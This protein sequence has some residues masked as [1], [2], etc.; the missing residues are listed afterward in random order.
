MQHMHPQ[1]NT[2]DQQEHA[3]PATLPSDE[4]QREHSQ[5][6]QHKQRAQQTNSQGPHVHWHIGCAAA[7]TA[8]T[9]SGDRERAG[10]G[11]LARH[12]SPRQCSL[13]TEQRPIKISRRRTSHS[14][15]GRCPASS[16]RCSRRQ[17]PPSPPRPPARDDVPANLG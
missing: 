15:E 16:R 12:A 4:Q 2:D 17:S 3:G 10:N 5:T 11:G 13:T 1:Q 9:W 8:G 14:C 7:A 6:D